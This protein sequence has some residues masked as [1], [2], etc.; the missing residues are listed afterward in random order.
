M[1]FR[2]VFI[3]CS[4]NLRT[5]FKLCKQNLGGTRWCSLLIT[6]LQEGSTHNGVM[7]LSIGLIFQAKVRSCD[8]LSL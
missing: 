3:V 2:V 4:E 6:V 1:L 8:L 7:E 5:K